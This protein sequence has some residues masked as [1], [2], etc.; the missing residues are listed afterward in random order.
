[1]RR[2]D[3]E[4]GTVNG[5]VSF[6]F[7][8]VKPFKVNFNDIF[9]VVSIFHWLFRVLVVVVMIKGF[10]VSQDDQSSVIVGSQ[11]KV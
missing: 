5:R 3:V 10:G 1:M 8:S 9:L 2:F 7:I 4:D 6:R 11:K